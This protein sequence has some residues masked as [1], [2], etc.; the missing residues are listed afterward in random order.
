MEHRPE[1]QTGSDS[2]MRMSAIWLVVCCGIV[3]GSDLRISSAVCLLSVI[4]AFC[5]TPLW[6]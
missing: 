3:L 4:F 1:L 2:Y 5:K 6:T